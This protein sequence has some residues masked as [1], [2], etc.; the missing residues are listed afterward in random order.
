MK[1]LNNK[2][3]TIEKKNIDSKSNNILIIIELIFEN[4]E[5]FFIAKNF[6]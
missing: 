4:H 6:N 2:I 1:L 3:I 5:Y